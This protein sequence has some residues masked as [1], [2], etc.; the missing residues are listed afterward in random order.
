MTRA[1]AAARTLVDRFHLDTFPV[2]L[3]KVADGLGV[4]VVRQQAE[5]DVNAMLIRRAEHDVIGVNSDHPVES[6][7]FALAHMLGHHQIHRQR[8]LLID[9]TNR[10]SLGNLSS[11]PVDREEVDANRFAAALLAP[12]AVVRRMAAEAD[13]RTGRQLVDLLAPRFEVSH[14]VMGFWLMALGIVMDY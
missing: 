12:E 14:A 2:D 6:Q 9:V 5:P 4:L 11:V 3:D 7:R 13:F 10:Y 8:A 1:D